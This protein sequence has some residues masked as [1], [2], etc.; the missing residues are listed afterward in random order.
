MK[1]TNKNSRTVSKAKSTSASK[2]SLSHGALMLAERMNSYAD[3]ESKVR[4]GCRQFISGKKLM[5]TDLK[6]TYKCVT[7]GDNATL[8][9]VHNAGW[10][11]Y[12]MAGLLEYPR[13]LDAYSVWFDYDSTD[14]F[15]KDFADLFSGVVPVIERVIDENTDWE[16]LRASFGK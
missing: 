16:K 4:Y 14:E 5:A 9:D 13:C 15:L 2:T 10:L 8:D 6:A 12:R 3:D 1:N 7:D 11:M